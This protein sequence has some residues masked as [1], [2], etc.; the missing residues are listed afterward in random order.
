MWKGQRGQ[1]TQGSLG[2]EEGAPER[3]STL[4]ARCWAKPWGH[5]KLAWGAASCPLC[6]STSSPGPFRVMR[7]GF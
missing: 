7:S 2:G 6:V 5:P 3:F 1:E 4:S